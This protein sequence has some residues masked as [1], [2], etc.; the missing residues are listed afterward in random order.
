MGHSLEGG[1]GG[2]GGVQTRVQTKLNYLN[3]RHSNIDLIK[4]ELDKIG[5]SVQISMVITP[6]LY[7]CMKISFI[8]III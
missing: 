6:H 8:F 1:R 3:S 7:L 5:G 2:G 4:R